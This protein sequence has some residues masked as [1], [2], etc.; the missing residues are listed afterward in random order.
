MAPACTDA[1]TDVLTA[2]HTDFLLSDDSYMAL[3]P[4]T[5]RLCVVIRHSRGQMGHSSARSLSLQRLIFS[6][7][8]KITKNEENTIY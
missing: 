5:Q 7:D 3:S 6:L 4:L 8:L 2:M 1:D